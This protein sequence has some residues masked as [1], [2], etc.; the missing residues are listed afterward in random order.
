MSTA[1]AATHRQVTFTLPVHPRAAGEARQRLRALL[2]AW[3]CRQDWDAAIL[4]TSELV[5]N[6]VTHGASRPPRP[7]RPDA[8]GTDAEDE[9][10][11]SD[12]DGAS[13]TAAVSEPATEPTVTILVRDTGDSLFVQLR[14]HGR[15]APLLTADDALPT[16]ESGRGLRVIDRVARQ[17]GWG[18]EGDGKFVYFILAGACA[19]TAA[20]DDTEGGAGAAPRRIPTVSGRARLAPH[21]ASHPAPREAASR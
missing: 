16:A 11:T 7:A 5:T 19:W 18:Y 8:R 3:D 6:A 21:P 13:A 20:E 17:W 10:A 12:A 1:P 2:K 4:A 15:G 14:D 9:N